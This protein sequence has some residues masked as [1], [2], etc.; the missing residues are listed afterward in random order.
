MWYEPGSKAEDD[1][2]QTEDVHKSQGALIDPSIFK[3]VVRLDLR[4]AVPS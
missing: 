3:T 2:A 1:G 4:F